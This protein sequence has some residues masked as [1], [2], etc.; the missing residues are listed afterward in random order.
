MSVTVRLMAPADLDFANAVREQAGWNQTPQ[1][2]Q[3][4][5]DFSQSLC[6]VAEE[7]GRPVGTVSVIRY[8]NCLAWIGMLL[9]LEECR[10]RGV[11]GALLAQALAASSGAKSI[12]LDAT[13]AG[14]PLYEKNGFAVVAELSRWE[15]QPQT[16]EP[17]TT[18]RISDTLFSLVRGAF[19]CDRE[20]WLRL[21]GK[22]SHVVAVE[23]GYGMMRAG[24]KAWYLGPLV[25]RDPDASKELVERLLPFARGGNV[26]WDSPDR[27]LISPADWGFVRQRPLYRMIRGKAVEQNVSQMI[28]I[29]D[30]A[31]G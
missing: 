24:A 4:L 10:G 6:F 1:D 27:A 11:G 30:P 17:G 7:K 16:N 19:G 3:A 13:P 29:A 18:D 31:T 8:G 25:A 12:G 5:L 15:G 14:R 20:A 22:R 26:Y 2:W 23:N 9:V 21:L 28:A